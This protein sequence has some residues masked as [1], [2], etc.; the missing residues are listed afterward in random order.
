VILGKSLELALV[1]VSLPVLVLL[2]DDR[3]AGTMEK[4]A[5]RSSSLAQAILI[6]NR[7]SRVTGSVRFAPTPPAVFFLKDDD[8]DD[9]LLRRVT[10]RTGTSSSALL[11][12]G[13]APMMLYAGRWVLA[14]QG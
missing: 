10:G 8:E 14:T 4:G 3:A 2:S 12:R 11:S 7:F 1:L 9:D 6:L 5:S 13:A